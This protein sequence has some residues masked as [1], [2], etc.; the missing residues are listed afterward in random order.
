MLDL[1]LFSPS[2]YCRLQISWRGGFSVFLSITLTFFAHASLNLNISTGSAGFCRAVVVPSSA[3]SQ[4]W[5]FLKIRILK[6]RSPP[7]CL[8]VNAS[9]HAFSH[10][11]LLLVVS[12]R[13]TLY[14]H[15]EFLRN[16]NIVCNSRAINHVQSSTCMRVGIS[17]IMDFR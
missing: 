2:A 16:Y 8:V 10:S 5:V 4:H 15:V 9:T 3:F 14:S 11:G 12:S 13:C 1:D 7:P 6:L 17:C